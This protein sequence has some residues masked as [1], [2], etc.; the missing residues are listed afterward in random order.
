M[1]LNISNEKNGLYIEM[2][3][4]NVG[5]LQPLYAC[6]EI[7]FIGNHTLLDSI[8]SVELKT[9]VINLHGSYIDTFG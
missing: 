3:V 8:W 5:Q 4:G 7:S 9:D 2:Q 6:F 1:G